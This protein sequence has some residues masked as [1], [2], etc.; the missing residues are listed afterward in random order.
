MEKS[1]V[2]TILK[3]GGILGVVGVAC[4]VLQLLLGEFIYT[5][6]NFI[7]QTMSD[8]TACDAPSRTVSSIFL[9]IY[10][11]FSIVSSFCVWYYFKDKINKLFNVGAILFFVA[12]FIFFIGLTFFPKPN[13]II[14]QVSL[15][16]T[17]HLIT[18]LLTVLLSVISFSFFI[19]GFFKSNHKILAIIVV[20]ALSLLVLGAGVVKLFPTIG[21]LL[22]RISINQIII[23]NLIFS[24]YLL[25]YESIQKKNM[26]SINIK[27]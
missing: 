9:F 10:G 6:Y 13:I 15:Q 12:N 19:A 2:N 5:D 18:V 7:T 24:I 14:T 4:Y 21:G 22:E 11:V 17:M 3:I 23:L 20:V 27:N 16:Y 25:I 1:K 26:L 8:F